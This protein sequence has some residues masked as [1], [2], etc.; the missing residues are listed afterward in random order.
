MH[1]NSLKN[2][3]KRGRTKGAKSNGVRLKNAY[4]WVFSKLGGREGLLKWAIHIKNT[5]EFYQ[6]C[7]KLF[8]QELK[9]SGNV[10]INT[11]TRVIYLPQRQFN[12]GQVVIDSDKQAITT[13]NNGDTVP[14]LEHK[15]E[16]IKK[17]I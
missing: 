17:A 8:D 14:L 10:D 12:D 15:K 6:M 16:D 1:A 3:S 2:L 9:L 4:F 7:T 5:K 13:P 11:G